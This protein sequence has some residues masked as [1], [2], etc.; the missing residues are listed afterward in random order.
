MVEAIGVRNAVHGSV[1][2]EEEEQSIGD[3]AESKRFFPLE[4]VAAIFQRYMQQGVRS[5]RWG[6]KEI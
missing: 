3:V 1:N 5:G 2:S 4:L 6:K